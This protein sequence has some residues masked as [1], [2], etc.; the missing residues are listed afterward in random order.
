MSHQADKATRRSVFHPAHRA[1]VPAATR[2]SPEP[3]VTEDDD[4]DD[5]TGTVA[6]MIAKD[7]QFVLRPA[8]VQEATK[9]LLD[10]LLSK[11]SD[12]IRAEMPKDDEAISKLV[13]AMG[14]TVKTG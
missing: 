8:R 12:A 14:H 11:T 6:P 5:E 13:H 4:D 9:K 10:V 1:R 3:F 2:R 7:S